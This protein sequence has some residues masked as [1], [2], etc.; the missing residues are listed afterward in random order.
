MGRALVV[1]AFALALAACGG[2]E[3]PATT[4]PPPTEDTITTAASTTVAAPDVAFEQRELADGIVAQVPV[5]WV[6][7][8]GFTGLFRPTEGLDPVRTQMWV[9]TT[10][11][12]AC[13]ART[14]P[15]WAITVEEDQFAQFA[16]TD[17]FVVLRNEELD[18]GALILA[19]NNF[20]LLALQTARWADGAG[21]FLSCQVSLP[22]EHRD[23]V[24]AFEAACLAATAPFLGS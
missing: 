18:D 4:T 16:D 11:G 23:L 21:E 10:C 6:E 20:E 1:G 19:E 14:A 13:G 12:G 22:A 2:N 9:T 17:A 8:D 5:G 7:D 24:P 3:S 15:E